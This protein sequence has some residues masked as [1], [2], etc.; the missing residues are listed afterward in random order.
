MKLAAQ[1]LAEVKGDL[2]AAKE[3]IEAL[4]KDPKEIMDKAKES[5]L[6]PMAATKIPA[7]IKSNVEQFARGPDITQTCVENLKGTCEEVSGGLAGAAKDGKTL[8]T[9]AG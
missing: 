4:P 2:E 1:A 7:K 6:G 3:A 8:L 5:G 9:G